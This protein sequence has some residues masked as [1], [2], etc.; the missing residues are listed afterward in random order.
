MMA[1]V[2]L[3]AGLA[4][5]LLLGVFYFGTLWLT[6]RRMPEAS[7]PGLLFT[8]SFVVRLVVLIAGLLAITGDWRRLV[9]ALVGLLLAR[10]VLTRRIG[11]AAARAEPAAEGGTT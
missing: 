8:A 1:V 6:V 3:V 4:V 11:A 7:R 2:E 9:A 10:T 5:G